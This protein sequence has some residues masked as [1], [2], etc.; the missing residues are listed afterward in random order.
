M[1]TFFRIAVLSVASFSIAACGLFGDDDE[2]K[3]AELLDFDTRISVKRLW[4]AKLGD[5]AEFLR[6]AL[7]PAGDGNRIYAASVDG[8]VSALDPETGKQV[9]RQK[10]DMRLSS[11]PGVG[12]GIV[13][14]VSSDGIVIALDASNGEERWRSDVGGESLATPVTSPNGVVIQ[15]VDNRLRMLEH[16]DGRERWVVLQ[17]MPVLTMRGSAAPLVV[18]SNVVAGFDNGRLVAVDL[19]TGTIEWEALLAPPSGRSD[20]ERLSDIDGSIAVVGQDIYA[21]G[22][23]GRIAAVAAESGQVLWDAEIS[24]Y[25]GVSADWT[26]LYTVQDGGEIIALSRRTGNETWRTAALLRRDPTLPVPF[27]T[28]VVAGDFE[29]YLHF[30]SNVDGEPVARLKFGGAAITAPPVVVAD[31]LYVQGDNGSLAAF[32]VQQPRRRENR[33]PDIAEPDDEGA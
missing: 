16:F 33:A 18:G 28:T 7:R 24:T 32:A 12:N 1:K 31:R 26:S 15:T 21:A 25:Q 10:L 8:N 6:V 9:W 20:L 17:S 22:Y 4:S 30:F 13:V 14:V 3:P 23:Q 5:E 19:Q 29:G 2:L 27:N 11:G